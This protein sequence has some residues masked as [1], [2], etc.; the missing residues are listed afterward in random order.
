MHQNIAFFQLRPDKLITLRKI[1]RDVFLGMI[2]DMYYFMRHSLGRFDL[3]SKSDCEDGFDFVLLDEL[4]GGCL[5]VAE[6][7]MGGF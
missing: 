3:Q 4:Y 7:E 2:L 6:E 1:L 5:E